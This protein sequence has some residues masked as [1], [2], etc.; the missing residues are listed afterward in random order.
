MKS[1]R[2]MSL[3]E[4]LVAIMIFCAVMMTFAMVFPSGYRLNL[5]SRNENTAAQ[6]AHGIIEKIQNTEFSRADLLVIDSDTPTVENLKNW[7]SKKSVKYAEYFGL[8]KLPEKFFLPNDQN[9]LYDSDGNQ[10][11][12]IEVLI[13]ETDPTFA[14]IIVRIAWKEVNKN[15][16][17]TKYTAL[18]TCRSSNHK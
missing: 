4:I 9:L 3:V 10:L 16:E 5:K 13:P 6:L 17:I 18:T 8:D 15:E 12:G 11:N 14:Y 2:G 1:S 7:D